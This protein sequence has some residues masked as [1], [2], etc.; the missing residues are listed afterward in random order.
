MEI[1]VSNHKTS[2]SICGVN[3]NLLE[4]SII[5]MSSGARSQLSVNF[6]A[7]PPLPMP[8]A[9]LHFFDTLIYKEAKFAILTHAE[10]GIFGGW[11]YG[12]F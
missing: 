2:N 3:Y 12:L 4:S 7:L 8:S 6:D 11:V 5:P 1:K 9:P 10:L